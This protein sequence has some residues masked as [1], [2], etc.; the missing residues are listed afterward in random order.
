V[1]TFAVVTGGGT[2]GHVLPA[3][4]IAAAL[5]E[6]G[7]P[8]SSLHYVGTKHGVEARLVPPT[9]LSSTML[10]VVGLQRRLSRRNAVFVPRL[11][12]STRAASRLLAELRPRVVVNVGGYASFPASWA[13]LRAHV[14]L[15]VVSYDRRPGLV[16]RVLAR[17]ATAV[18]VAF[19]GSSL[20]GARFTGA[21]VRR[22]LVH[23]DREASRAEARRQLGVPVDRFLVGVVGGSLGA[24]AVN[25]EIAKLVVMWSARTDLAIHHVVGERF[26]QESAPARED[27]SGILYRVIGYED[28]MEQLYAAADILVTRAGAGTLAELTTTGTPAIVIPWPDAAENHQSDNA[29]ALAEVGAAEVLDQSRISALGAII[30]HYRN[31]AAALAGLAAASRRAGAHH[32]GPALVDLIESVAR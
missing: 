28:R 24:Q 4:A 23:L 5:E 22:Q 27:L 25:D 20:P 13:A 3:M 32:R 29:Q 31:D 19:E 11:V 8:L 17:R 10:D 9:G 30:E 7:H 14:P 12:R 6:H 15:V 1:S 18:A 2:S 21:P 26:L 16:T